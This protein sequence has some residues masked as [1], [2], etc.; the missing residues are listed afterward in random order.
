MNRPILIIDPG[1]GGKDSGGGSNEFWFEKDM[2]L[3]ISLYQFE[4][5]KE[6]GV[7]VEITR[8]ADNYID[9]TTRSNIVKSSGAKY[10]IS[11]HINACGGDGA[12]FINSI[13]SDGAL[14]KALTVE[15]KEEGQNVRRTFTRTLPSNPMKD[16]YYMHRDTGACETV[17]VEYG[18][19][20]SPLDDIQQLR[21]HW[22]NYAE[23]VVEGFCKFAGYTYTLPIKL[24]DIEKHWA[25][26]NI[27]KVCSEDIM[28]GYNDYSFRPDQPVTRA[29]LATVIAI[30]ID[31]YGMGS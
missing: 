5:F 16:Y 3:D 1:H 20:D 26:D 13:Y 28:T 24:I 22:K 15:I 9:P 30:M 4:R 27:L 8:Q 17:I 31:R 25:K 10:C 23:A 14:A 11:N 21:E 19:A 29:E 18:F 7:P 2:V 6:L 12:E